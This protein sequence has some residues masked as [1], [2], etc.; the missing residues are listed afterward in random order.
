MEARPG[1]CVLS[2]DIFFMKDGLALM[3]RFFPWEVWVLRPKHVSDAC[4][5][6]STT[7]QAN[8]LAGCSVI[9]PDFFLCVP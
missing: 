1:Y 9:M 4:N 2:K 8:L 3:A 5:L 7:W 6:V